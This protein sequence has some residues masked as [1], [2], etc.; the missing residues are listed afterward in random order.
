MFRPLSLLSRIPI[1][2]SFL[3]GIAVL[4]LLLSYADPFVAEWPAA[5][6]AYYYQPHY[7]FL[8]FSFSF[9]ILCAS[10]ILSILWHQNRL[11]RWVAA[12]VF[13]GLTTLHS[14]YAKVML[15]P[16]SLFDLD[17]AQE[18]AAHAGDAFETY[19]ATF[20]PGLWIGVVLLVVIAL[21]MR[22]PHPRL[23]HSFWVLLPLTLGIY[24]IAGGRRNEMPIV[25][26]TVF[27]APVLLVKKMLAHRYYGPRTQVSITSRRDRSPKYIIFLIDESI[28][29]DALSINSSTLE[30]TPFLK[31]VPLANFGFASSSTNCSAGSNLILRNGLTPTDLPDTTERSLH[32]SSIYQFARTAGY[33]SVYLEGQR[34]G[35]NLQDFMTRFDLEHIDKR[36]FMYREQEC[37]KSGDCFIVDSISDVVASGTPAFVLA[38]KMGAHVP[39]E[40]QYPQ[41]QRIFTPTLERGEALHDRPRALNSYYNAVRWTVDE[42]FRQLLPVLAGQDYIIIYTSDHGQNIVEPNHPATHCADESALMAEGIVPLLILASSP[43]LLARAQA[44]AVAKKDRATHF[45][46]FPTLLGLMGFD[47]QVVSGRWGPSLFDP[48]TIQQQFFYGRVFGNGVWGW[49]KVESTS[50]PMSP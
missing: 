25:Y 11:I 12:V 50:S 44:A 2:R 24:L 39:Y 1:R 27:S 17:L 3:V 48:K 26:P 33:R 23:R 22:L 7:G 45:E 47:P 42:F 37:L 13:I 29:G 18:E 20:L 21:L 31:T 15:R 14:A 10:T 49:K 16:M 30:T 4:L 19:Q 6:K 34:K 35:G 8:L 5:L 43:D 40:K 38:V 36:Y 28:R 9:Q 32:A 46:I 41:S